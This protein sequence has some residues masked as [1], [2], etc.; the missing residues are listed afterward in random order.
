MR[1]G[2]LFVYQLIVVTAVAALMFPAV[3]VTFHA[4]LEI[5][6]GLLQMLGAYLRFIVF[7]TTVT[8][9]RRG[10]GWMA[11]CTTR[12]AIA[13]IQREGVRSV[14]LGG[15]PRKGGMTGGAI[16]SKLTGMI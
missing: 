7:M 6:N 5:G 11:G 3:R 13:M 16:R 4:I 9:I 8:G 15:R 14:E 12:T 1:Q 10:T 2:A